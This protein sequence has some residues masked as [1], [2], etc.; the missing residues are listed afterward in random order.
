MCGTTSQSN[1]DGGTIF[2]PTLIWRV[3]SLFLANRRAS[4]DNSAGAVNDGWE[5][6]ATP[7]GAKRRNKKRWMQTKTLDGAV[8]G[9]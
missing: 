5:V 3:F 1:H 7:T 4:D 6:S 8:V 2:I 9:R